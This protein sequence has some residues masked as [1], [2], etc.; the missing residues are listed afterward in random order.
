[1]IADPWIHVLRQIEPSYD[2][3]K[4]M[5][6]RG[7]RVKAE[8]RMFRNK[9]KVCI[10]ED[11]FHS[12]ENQLDLRCEWADEQLSKWKFVTRISHQEWIFI[13]RRQAEKFLTL[14]NL[15]WAE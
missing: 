4:Y 6:E 5:L 13:N 3:F 1:M 11:L 10:V 2:D 7:S 15:R 14:Y 9:W 8:L 12:W